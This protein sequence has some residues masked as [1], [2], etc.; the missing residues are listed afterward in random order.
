MLSDLAAKYRGEYAVGKVNVN[1]CSEIAAKYEIEN[2][3]TLV[4]FKN[5]ESVGRMVGYMNLDDLDKEIAR[6]LS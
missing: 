3:P 2:L 6:I 5:G 4:I 1:D